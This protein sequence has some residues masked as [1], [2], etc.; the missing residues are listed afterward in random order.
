MGTQDKHF[1]SFLVT[2]TLYSLPTYLTRFAIVLIVLLICLGRQLWQCSDRAMA[3]LWSA[4]PQVIVDV[5]LIA[6]AFS[7]ALLRQAVR[8][9]F[10]SDRNST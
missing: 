8:R 6:G 4:Y 1:S 10:T 5:S 7:C 2:P 3:H 9:R